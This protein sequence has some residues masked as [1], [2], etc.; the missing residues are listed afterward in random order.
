M[1]YCLIVHIIPLEKLISTRLSSRDQ[2]AA[3]FASLLC[4]FT[5]INIHRQSDQG[6][7]I[8]N[9]CFLT[10]KLDIDDVVM[11]TDTEQGKEGI[12]SSICAFLSFLCLILF[13]FYGFYLFFFYFIQ[14]WPKNRNT[15]DFFWFDF[16]SLIPETDWVCLHISSN[17]ILYVRKKI[18][19]LTNQKRAT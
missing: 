5:H 2:L 13:L 4:V 9:L 3:Y 6:Q 19:G 15:F 18:V 12:S 7:C 17:L 11:A 1:P 14:T 16:A 10:A 8:A